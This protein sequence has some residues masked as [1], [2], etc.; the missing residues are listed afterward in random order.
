MDTPTHAPGF[1]R[2][3]SFSCR[4][5]KMQRPIEFFNTLTLRE[6][7]EL[8]ITRDGGAAFGAIQRSPQWADGRYDLVLYNWFNK[9]LFVGEI[10]VVVFSE[11]MKDAGA[12]AG[13][14]GAGAGAGLDPKSLASYK[15]ITAV[16]GGHRLDLIRFIYKNVI[17]FKY[18]GGEKTYAE[19]PEDVRTQVRGATPCAFTPPRRVAFVTLTFPYARTLNTCRLTTSRWA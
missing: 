9:G 15:N 10:L 1:S 3:F 14:A 7:Y 8:D 6:V 18:Q 2:D 11:N 16:D 13:G 4:L 12:A 19:L 5:F 17:R